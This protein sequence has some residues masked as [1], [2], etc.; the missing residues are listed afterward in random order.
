M[1]KF[2]IGLGV[3]FVIGWIVQKFRYEW[4]WIG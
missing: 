1:I 2:L 3:G 4:I